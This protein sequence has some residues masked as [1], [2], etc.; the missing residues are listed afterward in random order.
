MYI[1]QCAVYALTLLNYTPLLGYRCAPSQGGS[2]N[3]I[4]GAFRGILTTCATWS[5]YRCWWV[6]VVHRFNLMVYHGIPMVLFLVTQRWF[7]TTVVN[8]SQQVLTMIHGCW[9]LAVN[10]LQWWSR[11]TIYSLQ[12]SVIIHRGPLLQPQL[13]NS[14]N[15]CVSNDLQFKMLDHWGWL[16]N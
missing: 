11:S 1:H 10:S 5:P 16:T 9:G 14:V 15:K 12:T 7:F 3:R 4:L 6:W 2:S 13:S 8:H